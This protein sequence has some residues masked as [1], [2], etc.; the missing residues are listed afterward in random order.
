MNFSQTRAYK[1]Q[2]ARV[3]LSDGNP[4]SRG[5]L[6]DSL[7]GMGF[8]QIELVDR[9]EDVTEHLD[10]VGADLIVCDA[11][12]LDG[13]VCQIIHGLRHGQVGGDPF[14]PIITVTWEPTPPTVER[15]IRSGAD[16]LLVLPVSAGQVSGAIER[17]I[18]LRKRFVVSGDY[19]GPERRGS[20]R[21]M[22]SG[23][24]GIEVPNPLRSCATGV[25][26]QHLYDTALQK[27]D[28]IKVEH[29]AENITE[30]VSEVVEHVKSE[31]TERDVTAHLQRLRFLS[32]DM[33]ERVQN[34]KHAHLAE[35]CGSILVV[36]TNIVESGEPP[37]ETDLDLLTQVSLAFQVG[38]FQVETGSDDRSVGAAMDIAKTVGELP[39]R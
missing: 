16:L 19:I 1:L 20:D 32:N 17:L 30:L 38:F 25:S 11:D 15:V 36:A 2:E 8:R 10:K 35:L 39:L 4:A 24:P 31:S 5:T 28:E 6:R 14:V 9:I 21:S 26:D 34:T 3:L 18:R 12:Q 7:H 22:G 23:A 27:I 29:H 33:H 37:S 13:D